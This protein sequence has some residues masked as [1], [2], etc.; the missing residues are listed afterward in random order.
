M[1]VKTVAA[2]TSRPLLQFLLLSL[3]LT[4]VRVLALGYGTYRLSLP[5]AGSGVIFRASTGS[6]A[7]GGAPGRAHLPVPQRPRDRIRPAHPQGHGASSMTPPVA[8]S[9][10]SAIMPVSSRVSDHEALQ[11]DYVAGLCSPG[12]PPSSSST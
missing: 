1:L 10:V 3:P 9:L 5:I 7:P 2:F 4:L 6:L 8:T 12:C 11:A